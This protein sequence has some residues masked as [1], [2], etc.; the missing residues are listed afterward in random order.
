[1]AVYLN[2]EGVESCISTITKAIEQLQDAAS[3]VDQTMNAIREHWEG[4]AHDK[5]QNTYAETYKTLLTKTVPEQV[6]SF[7]NFITDC[8]N[9][10]IE[11]DNQ[12]SG[13]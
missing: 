9:S 4:S 10:I 2:R 6:E 13:Q 7:N 3:T 12:L 1:M 11:V 8:K 5:A